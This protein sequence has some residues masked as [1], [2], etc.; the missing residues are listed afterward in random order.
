MTLTRWPAQ[1]RP[2]EKLLTRGEH[3]LSD[4]ELIAAF[5]GR[6]TRG[7]PV[8]ELSRDLLAHFGDLAGLLAADHK[9]FCSIPGLGP[10]KFV[11][12]RAV[13][14][15]C[16]RALLAESAERDV[17]TSPDCVRRFV[18][19]KLRHLEHEEF[20]CLFLD[21]KHRVIEFRE[22]FRGTLTSASVYPREVVKACLQANA[23]AVIFAHNHPSGVADPSD[24]DIALTEKLKQ[25]LALIDVRVLDHLVVGE[26]TPVSFAE[27]GLM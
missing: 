3:V 17:L 4:T 16:R 12:L 23:A 22:M 11:Q 24:A 20:V 27:R 7:K 1:E 14:E 26:G 8:M 9:A 25:A 18:S 5:L 13:L 15:I 2:R 10:V 6:G 19:L 21:N